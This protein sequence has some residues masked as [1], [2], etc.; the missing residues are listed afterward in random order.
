MQAPGDGGIDI[1][2]EGDVTLTD[3]IAN[4]TD[5]HGILV[6][7]L[8]NGS[9][10]MGERLTA[11]NNGEN[12][13]E[14][15]PEQ[16]VGGRAHN[17]TLRNSSA[18]GNDSGAGI[19]LGFDQETSENVTVN[20][21]ID[22]VTVS[23]S[24]GDG[25]LMRA[26][27]GIA[28]VSNVTASD[29]GSDGIDIEDA[30]EAYVTGVRAQDN[31]QSPSDDSGLEIDGRFVVESN[32]SVFSGHP[33]GP[34]IELD[35]WGGGDL[36]EKAARMVIW[37]VEVSGNGVGMRFDSGDAV[38]EMFVSSSN[39]FGNTTA[40]IQIDALDEDLQDGLVVDAKGNWWG[41]ASGPTHPS[42]N[43]D[44]TGDA[45]ADASNVIDSSSGDILLSGSLSAPIRNL[46]GAVRPDLPT[47]V[48]ALPLGLL[49][50]SVLALAGV[51]AR[52]L[53][54]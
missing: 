49:W 11:N 17:I 6:E 44:G 26:T 12:N 28:R 48:P 27:N 15:S 21:T 30:N 45:A 7:L 8:G 1:S 46:A 36:P 10:F 25:L 3:I 31:D 23:N 53:R 40:G 19:R 43:P 34:G 20:I 24:E 13:I 9:D 4:D 33:D 35:G 41:N 22:N 52:R 5:G 32:N 38:S 14:A 51:G 29:N 39:I 50:L 42:K 16:I 2:I 47:P 37:G 54:R 18:D